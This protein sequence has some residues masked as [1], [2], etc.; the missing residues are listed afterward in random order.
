MFMSIY[1]S[2]FRNFHYYIFN[3]NSVDFWYFLIYFNVTVPNLNL[4]A[5]LIPPI[6]DAAFLAAFANNSVLPLVDFLVV[7]FVRVSLL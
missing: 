3:N 2:I 5:C 7:D 4:H 1:D 6:T